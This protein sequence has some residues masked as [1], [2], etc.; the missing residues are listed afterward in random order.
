MLNRTLSLVKNVLSGGRGALCRSGNYGIGVDLGSACSKIVILKKQGGQWLL[1]EWAIVEG[2]HT[3]GVHADSQM[4]D[5]PPGSVQQQTSQVLQQHGC[6]RAFIG[7]SVG[8]PRMIVKHLAL[9]AMS[10]AEVREHVKWELDRYISTEMGE[11]FWDLHLPARSSRP[12]ISHQEV[13]L[14]AAKKDY[15]ERTIMEFRDHGIHV[16]FVDAE[17]FALVNVVTFNY[18][19]EK[20][21]MVAHFGPSGLLFLLIQGGDVLGRHEVTFAAEW[22]G[23]FV[24]QLGARHHVPS[25][26]QQFGIPERML[27]EPFVEEIKGH[28]QDTIQ[29]FGHLSAC[30]SLAGILLS[31]GYAAVEGLSSRLGQAFACSVSFLE[32]CKNIKVPPTMAHDPEFV[33][34][35]PILGVALGVAIRGGV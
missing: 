25:R 21:W 22:Y 9:P 26:G 14:V 35:A 24:D 19:H 10:E 33:T 30:G 1:V 29:K 32:P 16:G 7:I 23:D 4:V 18:G 6:G 5:A 3:L 2:S 11:V 31:G 17:A 28:I 8:G 15:V 27:W 12:S 20:V 34:S 13:L